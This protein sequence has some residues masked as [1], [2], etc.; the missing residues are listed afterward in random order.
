[1]PISPAE[2]Q[3]LQRWTSDSAMESWTLEQLRQQDRGQEPEQ[4][5]NRALAAMGLRKF[6]APEGET[7]FQR[8]MRHASWWDFGPLRKLHPEIARYINP[9]RLKKNQHKPDNPFKSYGGHMT[10]TERY[11]EKKLTVFLAVKDVRR[12]KALWL[13]EHPEHRNRT[14]GR[15]L[16]LAIAIKYAKEVGR[17]VTRRQVER[18]MRRNPVRKRSSR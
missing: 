12:I 3:R 16:I 13:Q 4:Q 18:E 5:R 14:G 17:P 6:I 1:M 10:G 7:K 8:A 9:P 2:R 15:N 11:V